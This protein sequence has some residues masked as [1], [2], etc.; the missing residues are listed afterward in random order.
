MR[1]SNPSTTPP[2]N[3]RYINKLNKIAVLNLIRKTKNISRAEVAKLSGLSAPTV[4]RIVE[5]FIKA[6]LVR[7]TGAGVSQGGRRPTMLRFSDQNNFIIGVDLGTTN[8]HGVLSDFDAKIIAEIRRPTRVETGFANIM[9]ST[10]DVVSELI[11]TP[12]GQ[13]KRIFGI[14]LAV[15]GL[16]NRTQNVVEFSP[17]FHWHRVDVVGALGQYHKIPIFC[18]NVTRIM[19]LGEMWYGLGRQFRNLIC[20]NVGY[21]IGAGIIIDGK[22]L[23][24]PIGLAG[25]F[26]HITMDRNSHVLCECG[27]LGCL[28]ALA[29]GNAIAKAAQARL[30]EETGGGAL[31]EACGGNGESVTAEMVAHFAQRGDP[32]AY[33]I[34]DTAVEYLGIGIAGLINIFS[35]EA[36]VIGGG[37]AQAGDILFDKVRR[38]VNARA[39][40]K[41]SSSV[42]IKPASFGIKAAVMGAVSLIL[43]EVVNLNQDDRLPTKPE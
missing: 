4:S 6:G 17:D 10:A 13:K 40:N 35:P 26:G 41:I 23:Y 18:D 22:P 27:N 8:I 24:G 42:V 28:E 32:L 29:S 21:G 33:E 43:S 25:E 37:V 3:A 15:A 1:T 39:L 34:F 19:A 14:G 36:V 11:A 30:R 12:L 31:R 7:E 16:V 5:G 2:R 20:V 38:T 9:K